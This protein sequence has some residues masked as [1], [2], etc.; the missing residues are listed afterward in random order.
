[1]YF[2]TTKSEWRMAGQHDMTAKTEVW[3]VIS[4]FRTDI[5]DRR[6]ADIL[7]PV[8]WFGHKQHA[9]YVP[10]DLEYI[11]KYLAVYT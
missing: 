7:S 1:M 2:N 4:S 3:P 11:K 8:T 9:I 5:I 10:L 6:Q